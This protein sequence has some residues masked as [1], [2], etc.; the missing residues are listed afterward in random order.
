MRIAHIRALRPVRL[1][2]RRALGRFKD[3]DDVVSRDAMRRELG[4][5]L[6]DVIASARE[7]LNPGHHRGI[8]PLACS[9]GWRGAEVG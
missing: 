7:L 9:P 5:D 4:D 2:R 6:V 8:D 1:A 3:L